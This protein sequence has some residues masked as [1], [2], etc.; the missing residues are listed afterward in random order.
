MLRIG[1][2]GVFDVDFFKSEGIF[3]F[4]ELNLRYGGSGYA[5]TKMGV[6]LPAMMVKYFYGESIKVMNKS[7]IKEAVYVNDRM[8]M[9]DW[10]NGSLSL[11]EYKRYLRTSDIRFICDDQDPLPEIEY[12]KMFK[13]RLLVNLIKKMLRK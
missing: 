6:N 1:F 8:C 12:E 9:D 3:Y 11:K 10:N 7:I 5:I 4:C 13:K 2:V